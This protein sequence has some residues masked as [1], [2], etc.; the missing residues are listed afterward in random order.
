VGASSPHL[1]QGTRFIFGRIQFEARF[2]PVRLFDNLPLGQIAIYY[3]SFNNKQST[4]EDYTLNL[5]VCQT[6]LLAR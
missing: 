6:F 1:L 3:T 2:L 5:R 4:D